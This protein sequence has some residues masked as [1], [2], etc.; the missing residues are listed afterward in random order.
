MADKRQSCPQNFSIWVAFVM[1][2]VVIVIAIVVFDRVVGGGRLAAEARSAT[3]SRSPAHE[4]VPTSAPDT[5]KPIEPLTIQPATYLAVK[6]ETDTAEAWLGIEGS[7]V[8]EAAAKQLGLDVSGGVLVSRVVEGSPAA[9]AGLLR[10][11]IIYEFDRRKV[12]SVSRLLELVSKT[13]PDSRV[14]VVVS[15]DGGREVLYVRLGTSPTATPGASAASAQPLSPGN[16]TWGMAVG[17]LT[18][19]LRSTYSI[20]QQETGVLVVLI[21]PGSAAAR[22]DLRVGDLIQRA[23]GDRVESLAELFDVLQE[24]GSQVVLDVYRAGAQ[25]H[26]TVS[27]AAALANVAGPTSA[28]QNQTSSPTRASPGPASSSAAAGQGSPSGMPPQLPPAGMGMPTQV[29][30]LGMGMARQVPPSGMNQQLPPTGLP[31]SSQPLQAL[32]VPSPQQGIGMNRP[33][34]VPGYDQTQSGDP[35]S[36]TTTRSIPAATAIAGTPP[37]DDAPLL[38]TTPGSENPI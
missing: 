6:G 4:T 20:P 22:A 11:D 30:P 19:A 9:E 10:G 37:G 28:Q 25:L 24:T 8:S 16:L 7:D 18:N 12:T 2:M 31:Q 29:P 17:Q 34:Y 38:R 27:G 5:G 33:L 23:N 21:V 1:G 35:L 3:A 26:V 13:E 15:R 32:R 14:R 36:K